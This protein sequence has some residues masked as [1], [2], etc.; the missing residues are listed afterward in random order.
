M[1]KEMDFHETMVTVIIL[2][3]ESHVLVEVVG[4]DGGKIQTF[5]VGLDKVLIGANRRGACGE[6]KGD[7][8]MGFDP[9][10]EDLRTLALSSS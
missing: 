10:D 2:G 8:R 4:G 9:F 6:T 3:R 1:V 5:A 7:G